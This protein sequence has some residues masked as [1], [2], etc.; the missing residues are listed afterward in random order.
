LEDLGPAVDEIGGA[1]GGCRHRVGCAIGW[2]LE[3]EKTPM[4]WS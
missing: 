2:G 1:V 4:E 3:I